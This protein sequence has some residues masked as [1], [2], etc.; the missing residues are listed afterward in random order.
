[1]AEQE[2]VRV[3]PITEDWV[4]IEA[5]T[6]TGIQ[7]RAQHHIDMGK[8]AIPINHECDELHRVMMEAIFKVAS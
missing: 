8:G 4:L 2:R 3:L 7:Y 5:H 6:A 1:M